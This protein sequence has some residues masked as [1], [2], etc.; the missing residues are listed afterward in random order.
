M[1]RRKCAFAPN[2]SLKTVVLSNIISEI[3]DTHKCGIVMLLILSNVETGPHGKVQN[4][5]P[6]IRS[7]EKL[8]QNYSSSIRI[9]WCSIC[10]SSTTIRPLNILY[11][12]KT[13]VLSIGFEAEDY[14]CYSDFYGHRMLGLTI[15][16]GTDYCNSVL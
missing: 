3:R 8:L 15:P 11:Y 7:E 9:V 6:T 1:N 14:I 10:T 4:Q 16:L 13:F 12:Y 2:N 5:N